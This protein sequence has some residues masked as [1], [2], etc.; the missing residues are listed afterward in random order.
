MLY[1]YSNSPETDPLQQTYFLV[2]L[3]QK[4]GKKIW[5][6]TQE[7]DSLPSMSR[8][9]GSVPRQNKQEKTTTYTQTAA[10]ICD[11]VCVSI[12]YGSGEMI[13]W[14]KYFLFKCED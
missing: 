4:T 9:L 14:V 11:G 13:Q 8:V 10:H 7:I 12:K 3:L 5:I 6:I 2:L 1:A